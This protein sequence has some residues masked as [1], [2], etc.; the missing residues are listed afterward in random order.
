VGF[1][2]VRKRVGAHVSVR[3]PDERLPKEYL[4]FM[5]G[6]EDV[7]VNVLRLPCAA[8]LL[9][10]EPVNFPPS[11]ADMERRIAAGHLV[12]IGRLA[13]GKLLGGILDR[14][15]DPHQR[16]R[17]AAQPHAA[18]AAGA[19][20]LKLRKRNAS[21]TNMMP[22]MIAYAAMTQISSSAPAPAQLVRRHRIALTAHR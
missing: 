10:T 4:R 18:P 20:W 8:R 2:C 17:F 21:A 7:V 14:L 9:K 15:V 3:S 6:I 13:I 11:F 1:F 5:L 16:H 22:K 19:A 12:G